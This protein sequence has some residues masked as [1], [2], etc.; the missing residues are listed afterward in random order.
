MSPESQKIKHR[1]ETTKSQ[2][3][4]THTNYNLHGNYLFRLKQIK[5]CTKTILD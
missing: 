4:H 1:S 2:K 5:K 3:T